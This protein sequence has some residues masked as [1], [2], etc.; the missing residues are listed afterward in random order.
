MAATRLRLDPWPAEYGS[1]FEIDEFE[2]ES[3]GKV[4]TDVE[5]IGWSA[6]EPRPR[7]RPAPIHF[8][9]GVRRV[10]ARIIL[11]DESGRV[12]RGLFGSAGVGTV[13]VGQSLAAFRGD[14]G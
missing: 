10:E 12:I 2:P 6:V 1:S 14:P 5:G 9:D 3:A 11:D 8:V 7:A 13:R 4:E